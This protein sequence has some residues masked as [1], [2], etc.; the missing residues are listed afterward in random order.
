MTDFEGEHVGHF[1]MR[2]IIQ[3]PQD[4]I[5]HEWD[6]IYAFNSAELA[7]R[8]GEITKPEANARI[9]QELASRAYK[10]YLAEFPLSDPRD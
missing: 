3:L 10:Q 9:A 4:Q 7:V 2:E 8:S 5:P 1:M 6:G